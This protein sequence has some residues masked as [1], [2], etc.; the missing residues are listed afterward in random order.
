MSVHCNGPTTRA[1]GDA[2]R[3]ALSREDWPG[4]AL[5]VA[6]CELAGIVPGIVTREDVAALNERETVDPDVAPPGRVVPLVWNVL[7]ALMGVALYLVWRDAGDTPEGKVAVGF[8]SAQLGLN[9]A[10]SFVVFGSRARNT[11]LVGFAMIVPLLLAVA[12]TVVAFARVSL[13]AALLL[14]PYL[15]WVSFATVLCYRGWR[16]NR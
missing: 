14:V 13:R 8:F 11:Y 10:W 12:V 4:L 15:A 2:P 7:F 3:D 16:L 6:F 9:V 1:R 5:A